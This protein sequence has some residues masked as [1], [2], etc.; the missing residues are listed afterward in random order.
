VFEPSVAREPRVRTVER[1]REIEPP[2]IELG[3]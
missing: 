3:L 1:G 2:S